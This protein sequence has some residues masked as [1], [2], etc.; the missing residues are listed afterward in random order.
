VNLP[1][2]L[3]RSRFAWAIVAACFLL[4]L[5]P[6]ISSAQAYDLLL[7]GGRII[8]PANDVDRVADLAIQDG[9]IA[10]IEEDIPASQAQQVV[11]ASGLL[12]T[13]GLVDIHFH[14]FASQPLALE[15][16]QPE[17]CPTG[18]L[19]GSA[20]FRRALSRVV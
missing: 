13:P 20:E 7:E 9:N 11:D 4:P 19:Q 6:S 3:G 15:S 8:D 12:V 10:A 2:K 16:G 1:S 18:R 5:S 14:S 17:G